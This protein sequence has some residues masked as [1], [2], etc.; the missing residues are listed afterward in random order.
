MLT[1]RQLEY[2]FDELCVEYG[3]CLDE[4]ARTA[5]LSTTSSDPKAFTL[6]VFRTHGLEPVPSHRQLYRTVLAH[7]E[8]AFGRAEGR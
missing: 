4:G 8:R 5:V 2:L 6:A 7:V 3:F 1:D